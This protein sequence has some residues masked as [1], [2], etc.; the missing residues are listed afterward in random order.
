MTSENVKECQSDGSE[1]HGPRCWSQGQMWPNPCFSAVSVN[2]WLVL[3]PA[4]N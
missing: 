2:R 1:N 4:F 3:D